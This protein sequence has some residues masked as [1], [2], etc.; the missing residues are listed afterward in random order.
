M[1]NQKLRRVRDRSSRN[2]INRLRKTA[3]PHR[4]YLIRI[5]LFLTAVFVLYSFLG[6]EFGFLNLLRM[7]R[8]RSRLQEERKQLT[9][10]IVDLETRYN[11]LASDSLLVQRVA[12][13]KYGLAREGEVIIRIPE[14]LTYQAK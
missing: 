7:E 6:G 2:L 12:R 4:Q 14:E 10:E 11:R 13:E 8:Y 5:A 1:A 3:S 9:A